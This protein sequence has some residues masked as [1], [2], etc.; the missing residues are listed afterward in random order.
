LNS[1]L[2]DRLEIGWEV[3]LSNAFRGDKFLLQACFVNYRTSHTDVEAISEI[4]ASYARELH[5]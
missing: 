1:D 5:G 3:Y 4:V 2:L